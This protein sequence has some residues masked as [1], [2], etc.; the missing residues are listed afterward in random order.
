M[1]Q[2]TCKKPLDFVWPYKNCIIDSQI[3]TISCS[4]CHI[5]PWTAVLLQFDVI[6]ETQWSDKVATFSDFVFVFG[7]FLWPM[8]K[9]VARSAFILAMGRGAAKS[10]ANERIIRR[11]N[12]K[13][14]WHKKQKQKKTRQ[15]AKQK[16]KQN[17]S[18]WNRSRNRN[19]NRNQSRNWA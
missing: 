7:S 9:Y 11:K 3:D 12:S 1:T 10:S 6:M 17:N 13:I 14:K 5:K 2:T 16:L 19:R 4:Q 15:E 18:N 8:P